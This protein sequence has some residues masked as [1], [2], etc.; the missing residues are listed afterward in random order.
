MRGNLRLKDKKLKTK[1]GIGKLHHKESITSWEEKDRKS[2]SL[3]YIAR[4]CQN[5]LI[6]VVTRSRDQPWTVKY[7]YVKHAHSKRKKHTQSK[8]NRESTIKGSISKREDHADSTQI[9]RTLYS[10]MKRESSQS[11]TSGT[12]HSSTHLTIK[13]VVRVEVRCQ[14]CRGSGQ[15]GS[16]NVTVVVVVV[17]LEVKVFEISETPTPSKYQK[18]AK[19]PFD[20]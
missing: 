12:V 4:F 20:T 13:V 16:H 5:M 2:L 6:I 9:G 19:R 15:G 10:G 17:K 14:S 11:H 18:P 8:T 1:T 3:N 7:E